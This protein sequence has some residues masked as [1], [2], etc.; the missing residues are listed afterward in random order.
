MSEKER[1]GEQGRGFMR[2]REDEDDCGRRQ[3]KT[4]DKENKS[5]GR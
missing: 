1:E 3:G 4:T 2:K 5:E